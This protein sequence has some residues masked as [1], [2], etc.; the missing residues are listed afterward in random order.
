MCIYVYYVCVNVC[1][2]TVQ[3]THISVVVHSKILEWLNEKYC[4]YCSQDFFREESN[5]ID[6]ILQKPYCTKY[7]LIFYIYFK[8]INNKFKF[9]LKQFKIKNSLN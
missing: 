7:I 2:C 6:H 8:L 3:S 5:M 9:I 1:T 4:T